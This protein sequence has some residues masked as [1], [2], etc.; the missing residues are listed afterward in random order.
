MI[1]SPLNYAGGKY[2]LLPFIL[3]LFPTR[4]HTFYDAFAGGGNVG[5]N[6]R[7]VNQVICNELQTP[8][9]QLMQT[10]QS[11]GVDRFTQA[12]QAIIANY[13]FSNTLTHGYAFYHCQSTSGLAAYN[14]VPFETLR[15]DYNTL[16]AQPHASPEDTLK[17]SL[18]FYTLIIFSFNNQIRFN[19]H[20]AFNMPVGKRDFNQHLHN[21]LERFIQALN[22]QPIAW[23]QGSY[24]RLI[25]Q[26]LH[27]HDFVYCDPPYLITNAPYN[28][29]HGWNLEKERQL[30]H[31]LDTLDQR[32]IAFALSNVLTHKGRSH[33]L[34]KQWSTSYHVHFLNSHGYSNCNYH[35]KPAHPQDTQEVLICNY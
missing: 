26:P 20:G 11:L 5:I 9:V 25:D 7:M 27:P 4:I 24:A 6:I 3:P 29:N 15:H 14:K 1:K 19:Q 22:T 2:R 21:H 17:L 23:T 18:L 30:L 32:H 16:A 10:M 8:V 28:E 34:L 33:D 13:Q 35:A 12:I 31:F